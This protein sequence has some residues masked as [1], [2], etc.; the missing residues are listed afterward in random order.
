[1]RIRSGRIHTF[2]WIRIHETSWILICTLDP[3]KILTI[4]ITKNI[5]LF[6]IK[7]LPHGRPSKICFLSFYKKKLFFPKIFGSVPAVQFYSNFGSDLT[8][9]KVDPYPI[10][11][12]HLSATQI[13]MDCRTVSVTKPIS[14][15]TYFAL[16]VKVQ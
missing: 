7:I 4:L 16:C 2:F 15:I 13:Y 10:H 11:K 3:T 8:K 6:G 12:G 1:M 14:M 5:I 9:W